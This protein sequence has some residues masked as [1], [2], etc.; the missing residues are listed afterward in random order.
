L[1]MDGHPVS[2]HWRPLNHNIGQILQSATSKFNSIGI[3]ILLY[4]NFVSTIARVPSALP[5]LSVIGATIKL[6][7]ENGE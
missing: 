5:V 2:S 7:M 6:R 3:S 1:F 4:K